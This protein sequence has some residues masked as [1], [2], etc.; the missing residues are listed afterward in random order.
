M[1][2]L[3]GWKQLFL[4][5]F[6]TEETKGVNNILKEEGVK[7]RDF[8]IR[9]IPELSSEG[10]YR[11]LFVEIYNLDIKKTKQ[12]YILKFKL[13]KGSYATEVIKQLFT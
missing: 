7:L 10:A 4:I 5:G 3:L 12:G 2:A 13:K 9:Q 1:Y 8:I 11:D 6:G